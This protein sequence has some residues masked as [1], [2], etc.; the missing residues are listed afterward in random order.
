MP[1]HGAPRA[2]WASA[3]GVQPECGS[4]AAVGEVEGRTALPSGSGAAQQWWREETQSWEFG[5]CGDLGSTPGV[6]GGSAWP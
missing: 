3:G 2:D 5:L 1:W 6:G 4:S